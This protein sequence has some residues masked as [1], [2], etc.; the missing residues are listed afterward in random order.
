LQHA[1]DYFVYPLPLLIAREK[2]PV[3]TRRADSHLTCPSS[4]PFQTAR[5]TPSH[6]AINEAKAGGTLEDPHGKHLS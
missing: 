1:G 4:A 2:N 6:T 5:T 3:E